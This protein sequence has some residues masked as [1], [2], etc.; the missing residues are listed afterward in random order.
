MNKPISNGMYN[1]ILVMKEHQQKNISNLSCI[2]VKKIF[3]KYLGLKFKFKYSTE[4]LQKR[5]K[6]YRSK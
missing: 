6:I 2:Y 5:Y 3:F 1:I 4:N